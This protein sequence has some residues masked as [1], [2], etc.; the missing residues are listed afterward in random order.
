[1]FEYE[2]END[3]GDDKEDE[4]QLF[5]KKEKKLVP[6]EPFELVNSVEHE[7]ILRNLPIK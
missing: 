2:E 7:R 1:M 5:A 3:N 6:F 4:W